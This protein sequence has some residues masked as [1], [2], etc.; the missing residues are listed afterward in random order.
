MNNKN[1]SIALQ[2][3]YD[4]NK[5]DLPWRNTTDPYK[6]WLSEIIL[7]QTRVRQGLPYY[8]EFLYHFPSIEDLAIASEEDILR[9]WQGL[10]YYSRARNL[11]ACAREI[12]LNRNGLFPDNYKDLLTLKGVGSYTAAAIASFAFK[13]VVAVIDGNVVRVL[14]RVFGIESDINT[15]KGKKHFTEKA[16]ELLDINNSDKYNQAIMEFGALQCMPIPKCP[17]CIY[18]TSCFAYKH[19]LQKVL[20]HK[21]KKI[22]KKERHF[23]YFV[24]EYRD[25]IFM[26]KRTGKDIW[27]GLYD[28]YLVEESLPKELNSLQDQFIKN[29]VA[30][31]YEIEEHP[32]L[33]QHKLTHQKIIA[34]FY[35]IKINDD[36]LAIE[37]LNFANFTLYKLEEILL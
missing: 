9:I 26:K 1:F 18:Q 37:I 30:K 3:W 21:A 10:G 29:L 23:F 7:Q 8:Q 5:R 25:M 19:N 24:L 12:T 2:D 13:E 33:Y 16:N 14:S 15:P 4:Q 32:Y 34:R 28:F 27:E 6:I 17:T 35:H 20:P 22:K 36:K 31:N 11:H